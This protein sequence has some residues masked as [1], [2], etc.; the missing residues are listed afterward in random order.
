MVFFCLLLI[1]ITISR[2]AE[3]A[4]RRKEKR[5]QQWWGKGTEATAPATVAEPAL[6]VAI[7]Q[8]TF[9]GN[10]SHSVPAEDW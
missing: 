2:A 5:W 7:A 10:S 9:G 1:F 3:L 6:V 8:Q 4:A